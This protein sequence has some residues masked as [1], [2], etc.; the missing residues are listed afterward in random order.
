MIKSNSYGTPYSKLNI[1]M[2]VTEFLADVSNY[3]LLNKG[4]ASSS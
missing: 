3:Q 1:I 4:L 2:I